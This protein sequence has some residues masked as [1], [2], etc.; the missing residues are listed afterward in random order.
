MS[1]DAD[2][3]IDYLLGPVDVRNG[4]GPLWRWEDHGRVVVWRDGTTIAFREELEIIFERLSWNGL[5]SLL[6]I[7]L[8]L[9]ASRDSWNQQNQQIGAWLWQ[10]SDANQLLET[11]KLWIKVKEGLASL[12]ELRDELRSS[13]SAKSNL[14][15]LVFQ[16]A[17]VR[18]S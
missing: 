18:S 15:S 16:D 5:P 2:T 8:V 14:L 6:A 17:T 10:L 11:Q 9:S 13:P 3:A 4:L 7:L 1:A 12:H